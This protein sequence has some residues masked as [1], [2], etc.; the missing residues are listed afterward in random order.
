MNEGLLHPLAASRGTSVESLGAFGSRD[1]H[2]SSG[3]SSSAEVK[4]VN[5]SVGI[6]NFSSSP[7]ASQASGLQKRLLRLNQKFK[8]NTW[9]YEISATLASLLCLGAIVVILASMQNKPLDRWTAVVS[10]NAMVATLTTA[11]K[12][13]LLYSVAVCLS[14]LKWIYLQQPRKLFH[15][16][17]LDDLSRGP[18]GAVQTLFQIR[19]APAYLGILI[20][21]LAL[22]VDPFTQQVVSFEPQNVVRND[23]AVSFGYSL[24]YTASAHRNELNSLVG[25]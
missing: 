2:E 14:Q 1:G 16:Q 12:A 3:P 11:A 6:P 22:A 17:V 21:L 9:L 15:L 4:P 23:S 19:W 13:F 25:M 7:V 24:N 10:I 20:V 18:L 5:N 8:A